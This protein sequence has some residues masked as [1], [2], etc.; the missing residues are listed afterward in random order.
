MPR[1]RDVSWWDKGLLSSMLLFS[2]I[3]VGS[4]IVLAPPLV[5]VDKI[6]KPKISVTAKRFFVA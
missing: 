1:P 3:L 6:R 4:R 2:S 5:F